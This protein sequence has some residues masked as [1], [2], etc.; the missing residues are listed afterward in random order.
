VNA[1]RIINGVDRANDIAGYGKKFLA[2]I[3]AAS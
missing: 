1:R 3:E 2:A